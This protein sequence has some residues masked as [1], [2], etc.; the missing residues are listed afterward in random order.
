[1]GS[2][3]YFNKTLEPPVYV[4]TAASISIQESPLPTPESSILSDDA[5][6]VNQ[7]SNIDLEDSAPYDVTQEPHP[8][9]EFFSDS[10]QRKLE[11]GLDVARRTADALQ[12]SGLLKSDEGA[13]KIFDKAASLSNFEPTGSKTIAV[14]GDSGHGM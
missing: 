3:E 5:Q 11:S 9:H 8:S 7:M 4:T 1:M 12:Q 6:L 14:L 10:F 13:S 2:S